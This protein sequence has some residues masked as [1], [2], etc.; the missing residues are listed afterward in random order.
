[1]QIYFSYV[2]SVVNDNFLLK[3]RGANISKV[4]GKDKCRHVVEGRSYM[5]N[6]MVGTATSH[7]SKLIYV[8]IFH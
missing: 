4:L 3:N 8:K 5:K 1:V 6:L 2:Y 7:E